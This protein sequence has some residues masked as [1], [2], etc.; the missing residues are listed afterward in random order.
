MVLNLMQIATQVRSC[1]T[2]TVSSDIC[3]LNL[4]FSVRQCHC[5]SQLGST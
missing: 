3:E 5:P 2:V 4:L 1:P